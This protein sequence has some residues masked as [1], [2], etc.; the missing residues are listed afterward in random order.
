[1][2]GYFH[3]EV[4]LHEVPFVTYLAARI[5]QDYA[6]ADIRTRFEVRWFRPISEAK[7][8]LNR[9]RREYWYLLG[10]PRPALQPV[11]LAKENPMSGLACFGEPVAWVSVDQ[12][13][14]QAALT[15]AHEA[16]HLWQWASGKYPKWKPLATEA[17]L[18]A[19]ERE[20]ADYERSLRTKFAYLIGVA[21]RVAREADACKCCATTIPAL[22]LEEMLAEVWQ[23]EGGLN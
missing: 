3:E 18:E 5:A 6:Q 10:I 12:S 14:T 16:R 23:A 8:Q 22:R 1:V 7:A 9:M 13:P 4:P 21:L 11:E 20:A 17:M 2:G 19:M 15:V